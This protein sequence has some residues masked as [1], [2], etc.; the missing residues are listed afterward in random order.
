MSKF[1]HQEM[2]KVLAKNGDTIA[3]ELTGTEAHIIHMVMGISGE[4]GELLD[5]IKKATI[6]R[7]P[8]DMENV[9]EELGDIEFYMEGL[10]QKLNITRD[11]TI[12]A[13][14]DKLG[15][16]YEGFAY[17]D[18]SAKQRKDKS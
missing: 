3:E 5:A 8:I 10:R 1:T 7:K 12:V 16:R 18:N 4:A 11:E 2:V 15:K 13:N 6:Y 14:M 17:S 9:I